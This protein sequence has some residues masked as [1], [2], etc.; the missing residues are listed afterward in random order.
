MSTIQNTSEP[1]PPAADIKVIADC[2]FC[3]P[4]G[5]VSLPMATQLIESAIVATRNQAV[6]KLLFNALNL[7]GFPS[8]SLP[9]RYFLSR[10]FAAAA[11]GKVQVALVLEQRLIDPERFGILVA[12]NAG[13]TADVFDNEP[14][15]LAW[16]LL[17]A[18]K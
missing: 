6:P 7:T 18:P 17:P 5:R 15:A 9:E 10:Q 12:R 1:V 16:L 4:A 2:A 3:R 14:A 8:P 13:M 11:Q